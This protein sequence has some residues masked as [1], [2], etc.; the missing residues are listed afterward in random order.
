MRRL[1]VVDRASEIFLPP[2][3]QRDNTSDGIWS[4]GK[5]GSPVPITVAGPFDGFRRNGVHIFARDASL[6]DLQRNDQ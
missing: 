1:P 2:M 6:F 4:M 3:E 5:G